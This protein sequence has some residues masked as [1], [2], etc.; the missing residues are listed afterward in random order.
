MQH[1]VSFWDAEGNTRGGSNT[2]EQ[3]NYRT[4]TTNATLHTTESTF[5]LSSPH[6]VPKEKIVYDSFAEVYT[7]F[8]PTGEQNSSHFYVKLLMYFTTYRDLL[9][10]L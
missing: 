5:L 8:S 9:T 6:T 2:W 1:E 7:L 10:R 4:Q 3:V